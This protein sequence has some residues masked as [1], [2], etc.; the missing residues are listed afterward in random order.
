MDQI[1]E[2]Y[3]NLAVMARALPTVFDG[4]L[5]TV[6]VALSVIVIGG[7]VF[8]LWQ[9]SQSRRRRARSSRQA[10]LDSAGA[11]RHEGAHR[12]GGGG[13]RNDIPSA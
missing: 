3:F 12:A 11:L 7:V 13:R 6:Q 2:N 5:V 4:F 8:L 1:L 9:A 10:G